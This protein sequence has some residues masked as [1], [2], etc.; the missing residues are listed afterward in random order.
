MVRRPGA[1]PAV[2]RLALRQ[3]ET[4]CR[5]VPDFDTF[6]STLGVAQ[7][8]VGKY[9]EAVAT[10][11]QADRLK[12]DLRESPDPPDLAFLALA[13]HRLGQ[14]DQARTALSRLRESMKQPERAGDEQGQAF[15]RE[16]EAWELDLV[17]PADP[18]AR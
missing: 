9:R 10:L 17:F 13:H 3:A 1:E 4:A 16:A 8:R 2:Y 5:L 6:L 14:T 7:Y 18:F 11:E 15:L 12:K